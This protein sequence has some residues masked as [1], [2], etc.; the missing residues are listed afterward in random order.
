MTLSSY[1]QPVRKAILIGSPGKGKDYLYSVATG[2]DNI[3]NFLLSSRG[4]KW[5]DDE[6]IILNNPD[7]ASVTSVIEDAVGDYCLIFFAGHGYENFYRDRKIC[8][9]DTDVSDYFLLNNSPRQLVIVDSCREREYPAISGIPG[10][11]EWL[12]FDGFYPEREAFDNFILNSPPGRKIVHATKSGYASWEDKNGRGGVFTTNLLLA[13]RNIY[14]DEIYAPILIEQILKNAKRI[15]KQSGDDQ[16]PE[17]V[18]AEGDLQV[19]FALAIKEAPKPISNNL[20][21][22]KTP[23][24]FVRKESSNSD[25]LKVGLA[26]LAIAIIADGFD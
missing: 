18:Y 5:R 3:R 4:G 11:E 13:A 12:P 25:L 15:I 23:R 1:I 22:T 26:L 6:I 10:E 14:K 21:N 17:I 9:R 24:R 20:N 16:K 2:I 19:P 8:L 7:L